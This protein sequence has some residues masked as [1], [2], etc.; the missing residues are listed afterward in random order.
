MDNPEDERSFFSRAEASFNEKSPDFS[1]TLNVAV[2]GKVS[3]G[4]SSLINALLG[5]TRENPVCAVAAESGKTRTLQLIKLDERVLLVDSP[6]LDDVRAENTDVT[7]RFLEHVDVGVLVLT[8]S[9][10]ASQRSH[11]EDI[12]RHA[13]AVFVVLNKVDEWDK[14]QPAALADVIAQWRGAIGEQRIYPTCANGYDPQTREGIP[15]DIRG[16]DDL[17]GDIEHFLGKE[18]KQL[19]FARHMADR[20]KY[21]VGIVA[22]ALAAVAFEAF[23]PGSAAY[24]TATQASAIA[25]L[26]YLYT[27][28]VLSAKSAIS[29]LPAFVGQSLGRRLFLFAKSFLPP[30]G[31]VDIAAA[32]VA[33]SVTLAMLAAVV[34]LLESGAQ[35]LQQTALADRFRRVDVQAKDLLRGSRPSTAWRS[36]QF[37][38]D[39]VYS[40][41]FKQR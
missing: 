41:L 19:L 24:I 39:L 25:A 17:R 38:R 6:G 28:R 14:L 20:R 26:Y 18:G 9:A 32:G 30:T 8:G 35:E 12:K 22:A 15:L 10:D 11:L 3:S 7:R 29:L 27:G 40:F 4:K 31:V 37:W 2:I 16:V 36:Q 23:I 13:K 34:S 33:I 21:A 5:R 1:K